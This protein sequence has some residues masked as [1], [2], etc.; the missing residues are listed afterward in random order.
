MKYDVK[1]F[2]LE[3]RI[4][5]LTG[6]DGWRTSSLNGKLPQIF[7]SD[8]PNGLRMMNDDGSTKPATAMPNLSLLAS[9]WDKEL[10]YL[11]GETIGNDCIENDAGVL[12][13]PGVNI[14]RTPLNGRNFEYMSEDPVLA[15]VMA[16]EFIKGVQSRGIGTSLKHFCGNNRE[17][18][19]RVQTSE[20]DERALNEIYYRPF[21]IALEAKPWTVMCSYNPV[22]GVYAAE[23]KKLLSDVLRKT[24]KHE[25][26]IVSDWDAVHTPYKAIRATLDLIM[27]FNAGAAENI[28]AAYKKGYITEEEINRSAQQVLD[29]VARVQSAVKEV[30]Y[31]KAERHENAVKIAKSGMV[32]LKNDDGILP[33]K[34]GGNYLVV[35]QLS[36]KPIT[37]G[38][39]SAYVTTDYRQKSVAELLTQLL[40]KAKVE[41]D[42]GPCVSWANAGRVN[43]E[44]T[45]GAYTKAYGKD[46]VI[47]FASGD[48]EGESF[49][50]AHIKLK[51]EYVE[52][53]KAVS[54]YNENVIVVINAG[55]A[56]DMSDFIDEVKAV[57][58]EGFAGEG[59]NESISSI[60]A[61]ETNPS[62]KLAETFPLSLS[63]TFTGEETGDG[64][65]EWYNDGIFVG[66]RYYEKNK[67][68]VLFPFGYGLSYSDFKYENLNIEVKGECD[69]TVSFDIKNTSSV[70]GAE[71]AEIYVK[72]VFS[73]VVRPEKELKQFTKVFLKAGESKRVAI[74]LGFRDFA[75]YNTAFDRWHAESGAFEIMVG[76]SSADVR[77]IG[78]I[79]LRFDENEQQSV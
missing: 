68:R 70:D 4:E 75:Y 24:L 16:C 13:A 23:N 56:I 55:S 57:V 40:P 25:S 1:D 52:T 78:K 66:Y 29:L 6:A 26:L 35:G 71:V 45:K 2:S 50:R 34:D 39:G 27:P 37:G 63:D 79:D 54:R 51:K 9:T 49:D 28:K 76:A 59:A 61:G 12:L 72:D 21:E 65:V 74:K 33:L 60:L 32:L 20:I 47:I 10:A 15:G 43:L 67:K 42:E 77:L 8:G 53:I 22:N 11:D 38:A 48:D 36:E 7:L 41:Y 64:L 5:L 17:K 14:K 46:A 18:A 19:R 58:Y 62:G 44:F 31:T 3:E 30:N 69:V 73:M